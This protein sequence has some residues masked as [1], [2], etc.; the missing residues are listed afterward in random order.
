MIQ[1]VLVMVEHDGEIQKISREILRF[2]SCFAKQHGIDVSALVWGEE[3]GSELPGQVGACGVKNVY[4]AAGEG[5]AEYNPAILV[6]VLAA[7]IERIKPDL[8]LGGKT[9]AVQDLLPRLA[10]YFKADMVSDATGIAVDGSGLKFTRPI[11]GGKVTATVALA[12]QPAFATIR[13]NSLGACDVEAQI[14]AVTRLEGDRQGP[15]LAY[16]VREIVREATGKK[17]LT[18]AEIIVSGG[19][20]LKGPEHFNVIEDLAAV[21]GAAVGSSRAVVD[22][23]WRPQAEQVGQTGKTVAPKLYIAC[24]ISGAIQHLA[25]M[26]SS[27]VIVAINN[28]P[29]APIFRVADYG[30]VGDLFE[31]VPLLTKKLQEALN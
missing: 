14:P 10:Q 7:A 31:I 11:Y 26:S 6:P 30:I 5:L 9:A 29:K 16:V 28:N 24:G 1:H 25:G 19:R 13:P 21:L 4:I 23:G 27:Q 12:T 3:L 2:C 8:V 17:S 15:A 22:A 20:G 18:E